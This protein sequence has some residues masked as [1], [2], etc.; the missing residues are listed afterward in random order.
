MNEME[1]T[2][3]AKIFKLSCYIID[4]D[5][6][7]TKEELEILLRNYLDDYI[8]QNINTEKRVIEN[9]YDDIPVNALDCPVEEFEKYF[10]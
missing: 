3:P 9:W 7:L 6:E 8:V 2:Y 5:N 4:T 10:I 1:E